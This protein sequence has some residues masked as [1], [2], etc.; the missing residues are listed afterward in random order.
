M[1]DRAPGIRTGLRRFPVRKRSRRKRQPKEPIPAVV[2]IKSAAASDPSAALRRILSS[3]D[4][5][6]HDYPACSALLYRLARARLFP[7]V[8]SLLLFVCS[9]R[10]PCRDSLFSGLIRHF[11]RAS[12]PHK[13]LSLFFSIPSFNCPPGSPSLQT[14]N[15]LLDALVNNGCDDEAEALFDRC[16]EFRLLP[17]AI[18]YNILLKR[19]LRRDGYISA[20]KLLDEILKRG[21]CPSVVTYNMLIGF[22]GRNGDLGISMDLKDEMI[23]RGIYPNA[24]TYAI[25]MEG[26][27]SS[28]KYDAAKKL[29]FDME[30]MG[31]KT[32][33]VN[34]GVLMSN[35]GRRGDLN[36]MNEL[37]AEMK[38]RNIKPDDV[39]YSILINYL[40]AN[41]KVD[42]AY[43]VL[44]EMQ[45]K[46][47]CKPNSAMYR[48]MVD[49]FCKIQNFEKG[50]A[51]LNAMLASGHCP[52]SETFGSLISGLAKDGR[53]NDACFVL[54]EMEKR[55]LC[56]CVGA[57]YSLV[58]T[59]CV[60]RDDGADL[61]SGLLA[62]TLG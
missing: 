46:E 60:K 29:M 5:H 55:M 42:E 39:T 24:I 20:R 19:R 38:K 61:L 34:Y 47:G 44:V 58:E 8:D 57:W 14:F 43:K 35:C 22:V 15:Q 2:D 51:L 3:D 17:N 23:G 30:Y 21:F 7:E 36:E 40:C 53:V 49:G 1:L 10:V 56:T 33:L 31:C 16:S 27:C 37:L 48:M 6:L 26:L 28:G 45:V 50:L 12:L 52:R 32:R 18:S 25:I 13:A 11:G 9:Q 41:G 4:P 59:V 54:E 62:P